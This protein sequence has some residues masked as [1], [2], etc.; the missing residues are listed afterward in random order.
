MTMVVNIISFAQ[1]LLYPCRPWDL[2]LS[3]GDRLLMKVRGRRCVRWQGEKEIL[4]LEK[5]APE[6]TL[7]NLSDLP[8]GKDHLLQHLGEHKMSKPAEGV[9]L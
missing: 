8:G 1:A 9:S 5:F 7:L 6:C 3:L 4:I 2:E